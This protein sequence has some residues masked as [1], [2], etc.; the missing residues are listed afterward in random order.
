MSVRRQQN[1]LSQ[2][3]ADLN[4]LRSVESAV[5]N[6]FDELLGGFVTGAG[7]PYVLSGFELAITGAI[8]ASASGLQLLVANGAIFHGASAEAGTFFLVPAGSPAEILNPTINSKVNGSFTAS[9]VNYIGIEYNRFADDTTSDTIYFFDPT[10]KQYTTKSAPLARILTYKIVITNTVWAS[11]ILPIAKVT[12]DSSNNVVDITDQRPLLYRLG[13]AGTSTP[14][15]SYIYPWTNHS[16]GRVENPSSS[17]SNTIN[18]FHGGDKQI[19]S[20]K[21][22][23]DAIMSSLLEIKGTTFWYSPNVGGSIVNLRLDLGNT[24]FTGKGNISHSPTT[25]GRMNWSQDINIRVIGSRLTYKIL[26]NPSSSDISLA[27]NEAAYINLVRG[28]SIAPNLIFTNGSPT[29]TSVGSVSWTTGLVAGDWVKSAILD[30]TKYYQIQ[31]VDSL[32]QV[33]L[34]ENYGESSTAATGTKAKYAW[35]VYQT[36]AS[37]SSNRHIQVA[38]RQDVPF[39][40]DTFWLMLRSDNAGTTPRVYVRFVDEEIEQGE[41]V[42][43]SDTISEQILQYIG[44]DGEAD[45]TPIYSDKLGTQTAEETDITCPAAASITSGQ[46]FLLN[47]ANDATEYYVWF[48]KDGS[49]GNPLILGKTPIEVAIVTGDTDAQVATKLASAVNAKS[50]FIASSS[51]NVATVL[52][53][54][55]GPCAD[56]TNV[57]VSGLSVSVTQQGLGAINSYIVDTDNLTL[58]I[59]KLDKAIADVVASAVSKD[60]EEY[61]AISSPVLVG[62]TLTI[63][64]DSR[65]SSA[66]RSYVVGSG[67]LEVYLNGVKL[68]LGDDWS[69]VGGAGSESNQIQILIDLVVGD[70]VQYRKDPS[71]ILSNK[72]SILKTKQVLG[73]NYTAIS[74]DDFI[75][76]SNSGSNRTLTL[77]TAVGNDGKKLYI[78]KVDSGNTL[79]VASVLNQ[80]LDGVDITAVPYSIS[81]QYQSIT[82]IA[83]GGSW[84][85]V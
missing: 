62:S 32:S 23:M 43:I 5:A 60:Y 19:K 79:F 48:N 56:A 44:S 14:N 8:G 24:I 22:W 78:K 3:R 36:A 39:A 80:T 61:S 52:N 26:A 51:L 67:E 54:D 82:M 33:T 69:E 85:L 66:V 42:Q 13:T 63:P 31:S 6:D 58:S 15:P 17:N 46:Y 4:H 64:V 83:N 81:S 45:A 70:V 12:T 2:Q 59:K 57:D 27:D 34:T 37:P 18:P 76:V 74:E 30:D 55:I 72:K 73:A 84:W 77:P 75:L 20:L 53:V 35:G 29:V 11:N 16:E 9:S 47:S 40:E 65:D 7:N 71:L 25:A 49:G 38:E 68:S 1:W 10:T 28:V 21:E 41:S 50:D